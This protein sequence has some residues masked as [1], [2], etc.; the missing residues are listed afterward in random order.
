M[1]STTFGAC[2]DFVTQLQETQIVK[3]EDLLKVSAY[4]KAF[5]QR[6]EAELARLLVE[7][8]I[9]TQ[10]QAEAV[11]EGN[12]RDLV[13]SQFT[14]V[15]ILG[16]GSMGTVYKAR[17]T[18][19]D[20]WYAIKVVPRRNA[21][22]LNS[23]AEKV[24]VLKEIRH[25]RVSA[26]VHIGAQGERVYLAWPFLEGGERLDQFV[27]RQGKLTPR[28][29]VQVALQIASGLQAYHQHGLFHGLLKPSDIV[30][31][32]DK[33]VRILDFG[34]GF[35]LA[36]ERGKSLLD[37]M[38]NTKT[39]ARGVDCA[40]PE[41]LM[42]AL[43][44]TP[45]GDQYSLGCILYYCLAG[46]FPFAYE[47]P[48]KKMLAHQAEK[49]QSIRELNG[50]VTPKLAAIIEWMMAKKPEDRFASS[51]E[52][53]QALQALSSQGRVTPHWATA[54]APPVS[55]SKSAAGTAVAASNATASPPRTA[56]SG[57][58]EAGWGTN[59]AVLLGLAAGATL[60]LVAW[61][62]SLT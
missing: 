41:S 13:L 36:S 23:I 37:T 31:G 30:I 16:A 28:Q 55:P 39:L 11:R 62:L 29:A 53:V 15:D 45:L 1:T 21:V 17:P 24:K 58:T 50:D 33:R 43:D 9:L 4:V 7:Q 59:K 51:D 35:L 22:G 44:R 52:V 34:V 12:A 3:P 49:P 18:N 57:P 38:T 8:K 20:A 5:P 25:P 60:G 19:R 14:L 2:A 48:V 40:S 26:L 27:Q 6:G 42:N 10:F 54:G 61:L 32:S 46:R 47:N 56:A